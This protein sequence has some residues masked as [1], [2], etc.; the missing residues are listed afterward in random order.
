MPD[1]NV[2][3]R[4]PGVYA[5]EVLV[6]Q[7]PGSG[8]GSEFASCFVATNDRGPTVPTF[9]RSW[10]EYV[11]FYG[12]FGTPLPMA[13]FF[14]FASGGRGA[15]ILRVLGSGAAKASRNIT[16]S[17]SAPVPTLKVEARSEGTWGNL[18]N[19]QTTRRA[20]SPYDG[21]FTLVVFYGGTDAASVVE[22]WENLSVDPTDSRYAPNVVN[23]QTGG[24]LGSNYVVLTDLASS[25][26]APD[27]APATSDVGTLAGGVAGSAPTITE[28]NGVF[29]A[30][31]QLN[32]IDQPLQVNLPG[33]YATSGSLI[34]NAALDWAFDRGDAWVVADVASGRT[35]AQAIGDV[36]QLNNSGYGAAYYP[37]MIVADP[38]ANGPGVTRL[39]P[40]GPSVLG[41]TER[42]DVSR[43]VFKAPAVN[44]LRAVPGSGIVVMGART[45]TTGTADKYVPNRRTLIYLKSQLKQI[46][47]FAI[48]EPNDNRLW[49]QIQ[50]VCSRFLTGF[51]QSGGL[52]GLKP[53]DA[54]FVICDGSLNTYAVTQAGEVRIEIGVAL[55]NPAEFIVIRI[56]QTVAGASTSETS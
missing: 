15:W 50:S 19:V 30:N 5:S 4:R 53:T 13:V 8:V 34:V 33:T 10:S 12:G 55:N 29:D 3:Y 20:V 41:L 21:R 17:H 18:I 6:T 2:A 9:I 38:A 23:S 47:Q 44:A 49:S 31:G 39:I 11:S 25:T 1:N 27:N 24:V 35:S 43:G 46:T 32:Q 52:A 16:D 40:P 28:W 54:F 45:L 48:F 26:T 42:T 36:A 51:W 22:R 37:W 7:Q 14:Y 56:G